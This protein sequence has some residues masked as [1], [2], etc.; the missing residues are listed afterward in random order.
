MF[1]LYVNVAIVWWLVCDLCLAYVRGYVCTCVRVFVCVYLCGF[2]SPHRRHRGYNSMLSNELTFHKSS[3]CGER[4]GER[5]EEEGGRRGGGGGESV[6]TSHVSL[7][8]SCRVED[9]LP[10]S[11]STQ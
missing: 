6:V 8:R 5:R 1:H 4:E 9:L 10:G 7:L 3:R 11:S 2:T